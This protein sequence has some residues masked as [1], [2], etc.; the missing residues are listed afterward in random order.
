MTIATFEFRPG[1]LLHYAVR[2]PDGKEMW[3][4]FVYREIEPSNRILLINSFSDPAGGITRHPFSPTWP[5]EMITTSVF[6]EEAGKATLTLHSSPLNASPEE[7]Q[8]FN[9]ARAGMVQGWTG[10]FDQLAAYLA[11]SR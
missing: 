6:T 5:L 1:G 2:S 8:T 7:E 9:A 3:G 10:T 11:L 4:K